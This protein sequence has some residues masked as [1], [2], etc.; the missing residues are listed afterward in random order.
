MDD[1][2]VFLIFALATFAVVRVFVLAS[3]DVRRVSVINAFFAMYFCFSYIGIVFIYYRMNEYYTVSLGVDDDAGIFK[4][5]ACSFVAIVC[6]LISYAKTPRV[7]IFGN[8]LNLR[9]LSSRDSRLAH[10]HI[11]LI[12]L[13]FVVS[14]SVF[15]LYKNSLPSIPL[16]DIILGG[17]T[18]VR[19]SRSLAT[20]SF[21]GN[22]WRYKV[23]LSGAS[24]VSFICLADFMRSRSKVTLS[25]FLAYFALCS[26]WSL[27]DT[28]KMPIAVY[29][30]QVFIVLLF[31]KNN[32]RYSIFNIILIV[33]VVYSA[34]ASMFFLFSD[35]MYA[36]VR[37]SMLKP[38]FRITMGQITP[39]YYYLEYFP[40]GHE[41]LMGRSFPNPGGLLPF[42]HY[43]I[44]VEI[45]NLMTLENYVIVG[46]APT[47]FWAE[48]YANFGYFGVVFGSVLMGAVIKLVDSGIDLI[49]ARVLRAA[50]LASFCFLLP[51][52]CLSGMSL[53]VFDYNIIITLFLAALFGV[54]RWRRESLS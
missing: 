3:P 36:D 16:F 21:S 22:L 10:A 23:V 39:S 41:F 29:L 32:S 19:L 48:M 47:V 13:F 31:F 15:F 12:G 8:L 50:L 4:M 24:F 34:L 25:F 42:E 18:N 38:L 44:A 11:C 46:S 54:V 26:V 2:L 51:R 6:V 37:A 45:R 5:F 20:N 7:N 28:Q 35:S 52:Y 9:N 49:Q 27:L 17:Q 30:I 40:D 1:V 14:L 53:L 33:F 43:R